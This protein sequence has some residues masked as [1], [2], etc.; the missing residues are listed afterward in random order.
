[1]QAV[2]GKDWLKEEG[3]VELCQTCDT[4]SNLD[5]RCWTG[6]IAKRIAKLV[7]C[8]ATSLIP[9]RL[10]TFHSGGNDRGRFLTLDLVAC[11]GTKLS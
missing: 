2:K 9:T 3:R 8:I 6:R 5:F 4:G 10:S 1:M 11:A 7:W